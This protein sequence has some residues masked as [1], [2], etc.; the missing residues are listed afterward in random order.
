MINF[1]RTTSEIDHNLH[2]RPLNDKMNNDKLI[3][4][5]FFELE[6]SGSSSCRI[7]KKTGNC[8]RDVEPK[9]E[10][11]LNETYINMSYKVTD[12]NRT[13]CWFHKIHNNKTDDKYDAVLD[14]PIIIHNIALVVEL[15]T[16]FTDLSVEDKFLLFTAK[17]YFNL[18]DQQ[19]NLLFYIF[20]ERCKGNL[21]DDSSSTL[22]IPLYSFNNGLNLHNL[23]NISDSYLI[24][25][26]KL[27]GCTFSLRVNWRKSNKAPAV[28]CKNTLGLGFLR[29]T[30]KL[31]NSGKY[32]LWSSSDF[33]VKYILIYF[34]PENASNYWDLNE[35]YPIVTKATI[36]SGGTFIEFENEDLLDF[37]IFGINIYL[38]PLSK[39]LSSWDSIHEVS[40]NFGK[41][42]SS[43]L[44]PLNAEI[45]IELEIDNQPRDPYNVVFVQAHLNI[46]SIN[47]GLICNYPVEPDRLKWLVKQNAMSY[48]L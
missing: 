45:K 22:I 17:Y 4:M 33:I 34:F 25:D 8:E 39:E 12:K 26:N 14:N 44:S 20:C 41:L 5:D 37:E 9:P 35:N 16:L 43:C 3:K 40:K 10:P 13:F 15:P 36:K 27:S 28:T 42:T 31:N 7:L 21:V 24:I 46:M 1:L 32:K 38:L 6:Y 47:N 19:E 48:D 11:E 23:K 29:K 18:M 2:L 30:H